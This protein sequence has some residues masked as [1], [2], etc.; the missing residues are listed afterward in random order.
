MNEL[1]TVKDDLELALKEVLQAMRA[2][3]GTAGM[4]ISHPN[5]E[6]VANVGFSHVPKQEHIFSSEFQDF[7]FF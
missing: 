7:F 1:S 3:E 4:A 5:L 2:N 6:K